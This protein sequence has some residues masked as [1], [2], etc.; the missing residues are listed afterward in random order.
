MCTPAIV[1]NGTIRTE[2][3]G[4]ELD[5]QSGL[6]R[7]ASV[8]LYGFSPLHH[9]FVDSY[10]HRVP[11]CR[12]TWPPSST[13]WRCSTNPRSIREGD[14]GQRHLIRALPLALSRSSRAHNCFYE[15]CPFTLRKAMLHRFNFV[16]FWKTRYQGRQRE[17]HFCYWKCRPRIPREPR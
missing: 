15:P 10:C 9:N 14:S 11:Y 16:N 17:R 7:H 4:R 12:L 5:R 6:Q 8:P 13:I 1:H 2:K 3:H